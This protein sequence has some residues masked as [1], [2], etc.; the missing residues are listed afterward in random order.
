MGLKVD[1]FCYVPKNCSTL[2]KKV[3]Y[4]ATVYFSTDFSA[5]YKQLFELNSYLVLG[6]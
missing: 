2:F 6:H 5:P 1:L 3:A 4:G